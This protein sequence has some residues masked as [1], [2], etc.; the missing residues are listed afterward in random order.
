[1][2][3]AAHRL[4]LAALALTD[5]DSVDGLPEAQS[6][7]RALGLRVVPGVELSAYEGAR[8]I[9]ILGLHLASLAELERHLTILRHA[10]RTRAERIVERLASLNVPIALDRVLAIAGP[11]AIGRP[12]IAQALMEAG[13]V[14]D[15]REAFDRFLG[16]GRPAFFAKQRLTI[17]EAIEMIHQ[18]GG[19]TI[20]AHPGPHGTRERV[21]QFVEAGGD[22][23][24][25]R[26]PGHTA[27]DVARLGAL[28]EH[29]R[30]VP[31]GGSD[32]HGAVEGPRALGSIRVP[33]EWLERQETRARELATRG[34][35]A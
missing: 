28:V 7:A 30:L 6:A 22:G 34:K 3:G 16:A 17:K 2:V 31:S 10:R 18:A 29:F 12:H 5:H 1:M 24:E 8:E 35:V 32:C 27:D 33:G 15:R 26:H 9:H 4:G 19:V 14:K 23:L 21:Q 20:L 25:V 11:G 13:H